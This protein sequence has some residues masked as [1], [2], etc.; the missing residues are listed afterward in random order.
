MSIPKR[1]PL[2]VLA[3]LAAAAPAAAL[4]LGVDAI[5]SNLQFPWEDQTPIAAAT[6]PKD[7]YFWGGAAW[8][9]APLGEDAA[10]RV[11]VERDPVLRNS[12]YALVEFERGIAKVSAGPFFG[13]LNAEGAPFSAGISAA[14]RLQWPGVAYVSMRS[15]GAAAISLFQADAAPQAMTEI[16]AGV[17]VPHAIVSAVVSA[18]RFNEE[19]A[20]GYLIAD[21]F[22]RYAMEV[23]IFKKN[24]PYTLQVSLGYEQRSKRFEAT[25][26][27]DTLGAAVLGVET[28][29]QIG[30][31]LKL[32][33]SFSTGVYVFGL[34]ELKGRGP[35]SDSLFFNAGLGLS[36]DLAAIPP[37]P[38]KVEAAPAEERPEPTAEAEAEPEPAA[39]AEAAPAEDAPTAKDA[40]ASKLALTVGSALGYDRLVS[41]PD[42][43][44]F[45][46]ILANLRGNLWFSAEYRVAPLFSLGAEL[47]V[48]YIMF[49]TTDPGTGADSSFSV[50]NAPLRATAAFKLGALKLQALGGAIAYGSLETG[51]DPM[52]LLGL[53]A[54]G[55]LGL[56]LFY[57]EGSYVFGLDPA[58]IRTYRSIDYRTSFPRFGVGVSF[59]LKK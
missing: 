54:G 56:G 55:R 4:E 40:G 30:P 37:R 19:L 20:S 36:L 12:A 25:D 52:I 50:F 3:V 48:G 5:A 13:F 1:A 9:R 53:E 10:I 44:F 16:S 31:A 39:E 34:D 57:V 59:A 45:Y 2:A 33:T 8:L 22:S 35:A 6:F 29:A 23:E 32:R 24:V 21:S 28:A 46:E 11:A 58:P 14:V 42:L 26:Q 27:T 17:Y 38:P 43:L 49:T 7:N 41:L 47:G 51:Y 15:D 18:K